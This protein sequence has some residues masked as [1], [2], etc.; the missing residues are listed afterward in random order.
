MPELGDDDPNPADVAI[1]TESTSEA[2]A[3]VVDTLA[4]IDRVAFVLHDVFDV[5]FEEIAAYTPSA[6]AAIL[7]PS[8]RFVIF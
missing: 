4:R 6:S 5:P 8:I 7:V 1:L 3:V 2:P